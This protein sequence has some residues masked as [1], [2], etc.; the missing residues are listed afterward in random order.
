MNDTIKIKGKWKFEIRDAKSGVLKDVIEKENLIPTVGK[1]AFAA[2][3]CGLATKDIGD[4]LYVAVGNNATAADVSDTTLGTE[5]TRKLVGSTSFLA[6]VASIACFFAAGEATG[7]HKEFGLFGDGNTTT[8][9][10]AADSGI[11][12]S[13]VGGLT[14]TIGETETLTT[15]FSITFA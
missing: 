10:A 2:Q 5:T 13:H 3:I 11:I 12:Y 7:T 6:G 9:S 8:C 1:T 14:I 4:N 15:T